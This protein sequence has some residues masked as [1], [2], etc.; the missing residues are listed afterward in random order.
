[1]ET[2]V[3]IASLE[4]FFIPN[5]KL[6]SI[7]ITQ[8]SDGICQGEIVLNIELDGFHSIFIGIHGAFSCLI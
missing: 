7:G 6:R 5:L 3:Q 8:L 1:M 2:S 4:I